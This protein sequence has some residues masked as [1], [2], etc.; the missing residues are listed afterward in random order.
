MPLKQKKDNRGLPP[1]TGVMVELFLVYVDVNERRLKP[2]VFN[3]AE[4][5]FL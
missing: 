5:S 4:P 3:K 2:T 1:P